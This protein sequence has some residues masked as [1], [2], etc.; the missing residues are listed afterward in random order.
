MIEE[1]RKFLVPL[2]DGLQVEAVWYGSGTLC[3]ST[4]AGC[5]LGCPFCA[6]G[7]LG[8]KRNLTLTELR[9]RCNSAVIRG[10]HRNG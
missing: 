10:W 1:N 9:S 5:G 8:F 3:L 7:Q 4:Q 2:D 6:S